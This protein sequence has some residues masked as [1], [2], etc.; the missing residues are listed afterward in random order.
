[1][2]EVML[3]AGVC[4]GQL[5]VHLDGSVVFCTEDFERECRGGHGQSSHRNVITCEEAFGDEG[6]AYCDPRI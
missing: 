2:T 3:P 1:M 6:C 5:I 4:G